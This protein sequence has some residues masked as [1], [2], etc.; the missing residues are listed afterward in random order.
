VGTYIKQQG[1][2]LDVF[3]GYLRDRRGRATT[4]AVPG[5]P[6]T[7]PLAVNNRGQIVGFSALRFALEE[8]SD[9]HGFVLRN[10]AGGPLTRIDVPGAFGSGAT[11]VNDHGTI[12]GLYA[13]S[14]P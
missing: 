1:E 4:F 9:T 5:A 3:G 8:D 7:F 11:G 12:V 14:S 10:G 13:P 2:P 6:L